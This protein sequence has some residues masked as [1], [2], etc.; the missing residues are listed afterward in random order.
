MGCPGYSCIYDFNGREVARSQTEKEQFLT[1][2][3]P[4]NYLFKEKGKRVHGSKILEETLSKLQIHGQLNLSQSGQPQLPI[5]LETNRAIQIQF[6]E[7]RSIE[8]LEKFHKKMA[9]RF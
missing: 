9:L 5:I 7:Y 6:Q 8:E 4:L 3:I 1:I 2:A